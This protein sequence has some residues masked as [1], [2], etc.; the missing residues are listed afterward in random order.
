MNRDRAFSAVLSNGRIAMVKV[1]EEGRSF[2]TL[3]GGGVEQGETCEEAA[4]REA[5][6]EVNLD[7]EI[8]RFLFAREYSAGT[9]YCYLAEPRLGEPQIKLGCDP[10]LDVHEQVIKKA[11]WIHIAHLK[12]DLHVSRVI[13]S[14]SEDEIVKY[15]IRL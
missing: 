4:V 12:D 2:W 5:M 3:P 10:E 6:E 13:A 11:E 1:E 14:L 9:E 7:V 15:N 8:I